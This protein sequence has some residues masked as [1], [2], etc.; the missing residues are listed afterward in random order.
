MSNLTIFHNP[1]CS[2]SRK[3]LQFIRQAGVEPLIVFYLDYSFS[4]DELLSILGKLRM[5]PRE[6]LRSCEPLY[7]EHN[8]F[9]PQLSDHD[10][11]YFLIKFPR[12]LE[13]PIVVSE[14]L[15][16]IGRPPENVFKLLQK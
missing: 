4:N 10:I 3:T 12:L 15:A 14:F 11:L 2:K 5:G 13:R 8:L 6:V 7:R 16:I 1:N 9:N